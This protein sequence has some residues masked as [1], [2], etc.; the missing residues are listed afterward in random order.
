MGDDRDEWIS[1]SMDKLSILDELDR[2][3]E[4]QKKVE[5]N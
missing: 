1:V 3:K 4:E 2:L 5:V